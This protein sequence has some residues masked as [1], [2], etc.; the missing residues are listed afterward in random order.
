MARTLED[1]ASTCDALLTSEGVSVGDFD[2]VKVVLDKLGDM[3]WMQIAIKPAKPFAFGLVGD[4]PGLRPA[5]QSGVLAGLIRVARP[6]RGS[7]R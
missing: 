1:T 3:R 4:T 7:A 5:R 2:H 6:A